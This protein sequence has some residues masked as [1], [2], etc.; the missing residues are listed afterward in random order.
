ML[1]EEVIDKVV[2][3][4]VN[5]IEQGNEYILKKIGEN[6]KQ[7]R[8]VKPSEA[9]RLYQIIRYGGDYD[10]IVKRLSE[11]TE[12]NVNDIYNIFN[13]VAKND[14]LFAKQ[15]YEYRNK[16]YIPYEENAFLK[17][18]VEALARI[19]AKKYINLTNTLA[20]TE[21]KKG[22]VV[23]TK[24]SKKYFEVLD[25]AVLNVGQGKENFDSAMYRSIKRLGESGIRTVDYE[26]GRSLRVDSAVRM[27]MQG[28]LTNLHEEI[29]E[30]F[31][32]E[33]GADGKEIT[34]H[35]NPAPD[36]AEVQGHQFKIEEFEKFQ[37]DQ[38]CKDVNNVLFPAT[39]NGRD[40]RSIGQYNCRHYTF[41]IV[42]GVSEP[43][44]T[45][46]QLQE[47]INNNNKGFEFEGKHYTN[48][49]GTQL[50]RRLETEIR[51]QKDLQIIA[52]ASKNEDLLTDIENA[53]NNISRLTKKYHELSKAGNL[54]E[55]M[56]RMRV[57]GFKRV[58]TKRKQR[59]NLVA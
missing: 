57:S 49:E 4:L 39:F 6:I 7:F 54:T 8:D 24:L 34:V 10:K 26:S 11:I 47:I 37:N 32:K 53:Q 13:E 40:R 51:K 56:E 48:Y 46:E 44:Y 42:V 1:S 18:Q 15:F 50:Q 16:K 20:F 55:Y 3:R 25:E 17:N 22:K 28:A 2:E 5:R 43:E 31:G 19:T 9:Q 21:H 58:A 14:Y 41:N 36:H 52:R 29:Q 12:L 35:L 45:P 23:Y 59:Y 30:T 38:D 33:Y 27:Q